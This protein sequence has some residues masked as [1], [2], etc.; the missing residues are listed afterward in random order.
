MPPMRVVTEFGDKNSGPKKTLA[1]NSSEGEAKPATTPPKRDV[2]PQQMPTEAAA[3]KPKTETPPS[4]PVPDDV[5]LP[6]VAAADASPEPN[7]PPADVSGEAKTSI[8]QTKA[9]AQKTP[10]KPKEV[11]KNND[12][13]NAK[14][15]FS[16]TED[17]NSLAQSAV[18]GLPRSKRVAVLCASELRAQLAY[19]SPSY[20]P[21]ALPQYG[22][23]AGT[24]LN[25]DD[26]AFGTAK[27][28]YHVR[29][30]CEVDADATKVVSFAHEVGGLIPRNQYGKY[31]IRE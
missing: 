29:F 25:I 5:K 15:L 31:D 23:R 21:Y 19:G 24:L 26:A 10:E 28:W 18:D 30:R 11:V 22:L 27:G 17:G 1:G 3:E 8:E 16:S 7:G 13:A 4:R 6:E 9:P 14:T 2:E 20:Q 12:L